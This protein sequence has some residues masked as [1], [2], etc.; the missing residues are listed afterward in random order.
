MGL[1][2]CL[3]CLYRLPGGIC[4]MMGLCSVLLLSWHVRKD[5]EFRDQV[6]RWVR[7]WKFWEFSFIQSW[8]LLFQLIPFLIF[9]AFV[10]FFLI[11]ETRF[12]AWT[13]VLMKTFAVQV[14]W[15]LPLIVTSFLFL[16]LL[17]RLSH[18]L[19]LVLLFVLSILPLHGRTSTCL[20]TCSCLSHASSYTSHISVFAQ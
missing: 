3:W 4:L 15:N 18:V 5:F 12:H 14:R 8:S 1:L 16:P 6:T 2:G 13:K 9:K 20:H 7:R 17:A 10:S 11:L 19:P